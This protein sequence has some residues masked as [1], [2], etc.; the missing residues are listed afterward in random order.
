MELIFILSTL[1][2]PLLLAAMGG[3]TSERSGIMNIALEG[4][5]LTS[6]CVVAV[7][8]VATGNPVVGVLA[9]LA[10]AIVMALLHALLT[11]AY[12]IDHIISG[13]A[14]NLVALGGTNFLDKRFT[15]LSRQGEIPQI[16]MLVFDVLAF[17]LPV[18]LW[19]YLKR[20]RGGL[21]LLAV[22]NDPDKARQM[23]VDPIRVRYAALAATGL[24]CGL[25][26]AMIVTN[27]GRFTDGMT[28]GRG[29]IALAALILGGWKP[30]PTAVACLGFGAL[31]TLQLQLQGSQLFG[32][33][34]P[35]QFWNALP[36]LVT[37]I[38][39]AGFLGKSRAPA[40][41]GKE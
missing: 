12:R 7:V 14:I 10:A 23:G 34:L 20:T 39:M 26:G 24:L 40:G 22:G 31:Y 5:M 36:Y 41:L 6:A 28:A 19:L 18:L 1:T 13:M 37:V 32:A 9:G 8:S 2:G 15:D 27:A 25:S 30:I 16:P 35:S 29:F 11:Q 21:R 38:A 3:L 33:N 17:G 4:F